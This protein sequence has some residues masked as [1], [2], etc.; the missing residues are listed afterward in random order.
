MA[1]HRRLLFLNYEYPPIGGGGGNATMH[2]GRELAAMGDEV[3]VLTAAWGDLPLTADDHGVRVRRIAAF[4]QRPDRCSVP[5]MVAYM[6]AAAPVASE[7]IRK[8]AID[9]VLAFFA[10]PTAP[11]AWWTRRR[12][13]A[14]YAISLQ[15]GD[16]PGFTPDQL[17]GWHRLTGG[18]IRHLW[19]DAGAVVANSEGLAALARVHAPEVEIGVIPAGV[20]V[21][22]GTAKIDYDA[23]GPV[24]LLFVG[25]LVPQ[26]GLD[27]LLDALSLLTRDVRWT[28]TLAGDGPEWTRLVAQAARNGVHDRIKFLGWSSKE[29]LAQIYRSA[30]V[31]VLPSRDEGMS[32]ALL[33]AM[34]TGLPV[35]CTDVAG[36]RDVITDGENG[37]IVPPVHPPALMAALAEL[38]P[39]AGRRAAMGRAARNRVVRQ[40]SWTRAAK[41]W[42]DILHRL[43]DSRG[44]A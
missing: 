9:A 20:A 16:V 11:T 7:I 33:E 42:R 36:M 28:L 26:K 10:L 24:N 27:V 6:L 37:L 17:K 15:G 8:H 13:G 35:V 4:R 19:R 3:H 1:Q 2:I 41:S 34:A 5:E 23:E 21:D 31:F 18:V 12:T 32:N 25:R 30:D 39:D 44:P 43:A 22:T 14:P 40:F 29:Q 38:M